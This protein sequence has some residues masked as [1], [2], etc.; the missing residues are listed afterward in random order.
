M[1]LSL[2][3]VLVFVMRHSGVVGELSSGRIERNSDAGLNVFTGPMGQL[4]DYIS[5]TNLRSWCV[6]GVDGK[7][8]PGWHAIEAEDYSKIFSR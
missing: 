6:L 4:N 2:T 1:P 8:M 5:G 3:T 7:P